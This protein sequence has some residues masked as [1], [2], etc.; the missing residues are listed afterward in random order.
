MKKT[1]ISM[2]V[3]SAM[4]V[5]ASAFAVDVSGFADVQ[6]TV[7]DDSQDNMSGPSGTDNPANNQFA[8]TGEVD[9]THTAGDVTVRADVDLTLSGSTSGSLEQAMVVWNAN[10]AVTVIGGV[11]NNPIGQDAE[12]IVDQRFTSHS[13][14]YNVLDHQTALNGNNVAGVAL[15]GMV[16]PATITAAVLNDLGGGTNHS[17]PNA[18]NAVGKN[19]LALNINLSPSAVPGLDLELGFASQEGYNAT[20]NKGSAG[21]VID[22]NAAYNVQNMFA[23]GLDYLKPSDLVDSAYD[24]WAKGAVGMGTDVGLR[25]SS[26]SWDSAVLG[27][28]VSDNTSTTFFVSKAIGNNLDVALEYRS[29]SGNK[30]GGAITGGMVTTTDA[31]SRLPDGTQTWINITGKF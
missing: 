31:V 19:S 9:F 30:A 5:P 17:T 26:V 23:V 18:S 3:A 27:N 14:T 21:N 2:A 8:A 10:Q 13:A 6:L 12:D 15:A 28:A 20:D 22:F 25:Y 4:V 16:G 7:T 11:F 24:I 1:L 29:N